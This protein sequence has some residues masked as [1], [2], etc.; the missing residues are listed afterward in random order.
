MGNLFYTNWG[1]RTHWE[2]NIST[3]AII[4]NKKNSPAAIKKTYQKAQLI[5]KHT[6]SDNYMKTTKK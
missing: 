1:L 4:Y 5:N 3:A 2:K 6:Y